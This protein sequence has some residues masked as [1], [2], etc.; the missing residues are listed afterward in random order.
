[1]LYINPIEILELAN[2]NPNEIDSTLIKKA[3]RRLFADIELSDSG[4][5]DYHGQQL[6]KSDCERAIDEL[7]DPNNKEFY[8]H[9]SNNVALNRFLATGD[10]A[11][12]K[13]LR[14]ESIYQ[15]PAEALV[16][17]ELSNSKRTKRVSNL[18]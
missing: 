11:Y 2:Q 4:L 15:L 13:K 17:H 8:A 1:M 5:Y 10:Q 9:L 12:L 18:V 16:R 7:E 3:K 6:T 14:Q